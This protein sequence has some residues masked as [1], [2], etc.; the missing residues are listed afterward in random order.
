MLRSQKAV[1]FTHDPFLS[2]IASCIRDN[3][4]FGQL[5]LGSPND[6]SLPHPVKEIEDEGCTFVTAGVNCI[7]V[8][9][10]H[11]RHYEGRPPVDVRTG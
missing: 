11:C 5:G 8:E 6:E 10:S 2:P 7:L 9:C 4:Q 1:I 3:S